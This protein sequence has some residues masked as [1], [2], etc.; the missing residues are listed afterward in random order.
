MLH[1][2]VSSVPTRGLHEKSGASQLYERL[3]KK[4]FDRRKES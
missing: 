4:L 3:F 2:P 1:G